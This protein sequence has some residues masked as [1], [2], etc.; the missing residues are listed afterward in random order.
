MY[1]FF[2]DSEYMTDRQGDGQTENRTDI[3]ILEHGPSE[4]WHI[5]GIECY[6]SH[7]YWN[8]KVVQ[9]MQ[10]RIH[11]W[12]ITPAAAVGMAD[13]SQF[14]RLNI[15]IITLIKW[16]DYIYNYINI[17]PWC[18]KRSIVACVSRWNWKRWLT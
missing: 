14:I 1:P 3:T 13:M 2:W 11:S 9:R 8:V 15:Y 4:D 16:V 17:I 10:R 5:K 7:E 6:N 18:S 12:V